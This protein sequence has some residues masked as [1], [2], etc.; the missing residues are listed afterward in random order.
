M[1][2]ERARRHPGLSLSRLQPT[3][4][5]VVGAGL[6]GEPGDGGFGIFSGPAGDEF[7]QGVEA[8]A[9]VPETRGEGVERAGGVG[10]ADDGEQGADKAGARIGEGEGA[11]GVLF[12]E[13]G[14]RVGGEP[15]CVCF[16]G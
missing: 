1:A 15:A 11:G 4:K 9:A 12:G 8:A 2:S 16:F 13:A 3:R 5:S 10:A 14:E 6:G 7:A